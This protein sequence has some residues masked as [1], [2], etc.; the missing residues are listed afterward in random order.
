MRCVT[1]PF[2]SLPPHALMFS[3]TLFSAN[4]ENIAYP[5]GSDPVLIGRSKECSVQLRY[6]GQASKVHC[7]IEVTEGKWKIT[8]LESVNGTCK[9]S[10]DFA[11]HPTGWRAYP[12]RLYSVYLRFGRPLEI[13]VSRLAACTYNNEGYD[14]EEY[15]ECQYHRYEY[16]RMEWLVLYVVQPQLSEF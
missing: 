6:D 1:F 14:E 7:Q 2:I 5:I 3:H 4:E 12:G 13:V 10:T 15:D 16:I 9:Q 11:P 8:D